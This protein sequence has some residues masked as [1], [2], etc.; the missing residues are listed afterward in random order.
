[1]KVTVEVDCT[2]VE[3]RA[4]LGLP[5][6]SA[7]NDHMVGEM[8]ARFEKN[9]ALVDLEPMMKGWMTLGGQ[10]QEALLNIMGKAARAASEKK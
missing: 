4:F 8:I 2:P 9:A 5:D 3:A 10:A 6:V 1:M 7:F